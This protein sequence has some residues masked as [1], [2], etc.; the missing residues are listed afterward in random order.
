MRPLTRPRSRSRCTPTRILSSG[1]SSAVSKSSMRIGTCPSK[2]LSSTRNPEA[3]T[4]EGSQPRILLGSPVPAV[5][6]AFNRSSENSRP[7]SRATSRAGCAS[8]QVGL[9]V[10][11][12]QI[13]QLGVLVLGDGNNGACHRDRIGLGEFLDAFAH[14]QAPLNIGRCLFRSL[15]SHDRSARPDVGLK[16]SRFDQHNLYAERVH[17]HTQRFAPSLQCVFRG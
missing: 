12:H 14:A 5:V 6:E 4:P 16:R 10:A 13:A 1:K 3:S 9:S 7:P 11:P 15:L 17:F 8:W 2:W